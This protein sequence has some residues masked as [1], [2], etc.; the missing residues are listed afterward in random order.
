MTDKE[1]RLGVAEQPESRVAEKD[2]DVTYG[3]LKQIGDISPELDAHEQ[4]IL[5]RKLYVYLIPLLIVIN[6]MMFVGNCPA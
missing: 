1:A 6:L 2:A 3:L 5:R 4:K